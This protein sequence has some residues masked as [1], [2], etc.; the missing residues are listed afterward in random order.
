MSQANR[1]EHLCVLRRQVLRLTAG[2]TTQDE[3]LSGLPVVGDEQSL[4]EAREAVSML[5]E[6]GYLRRWQYAGV[7][8]VQRTESGARQSN[9]L[10]AELDPA[11]WGG[12]AFGRG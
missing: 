10:T 6:L 3:L 11:I 2:P 1:A 12:L 9:K 5:V 7:A 8:W 4:G